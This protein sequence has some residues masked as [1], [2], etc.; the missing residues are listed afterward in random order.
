[1]RSWRERL[2]AAVELE[3]A[4]P[5]SPLAALWTFPAMIGSAF[6]VS[7]GAEAAEFLMSQGLALAV[8]ALVQ[9]MPEFA[10]EAVIAW[11]AGKDP[12]MVHLA[13][14]NFT[15]SLR[16]LT[17]LGWP[18]IYG[19]AA[20]FSRRK[21]RRLGRIVLADDHAV[22]VLGLLPPLAYFVVVWAKSNLSLID[23][24]VLA[25][26]YVAYLAVLLRM[27]PRDELPE[28][29]GELPRVSRWALSYTG[30]KR[31]AAVMALLGGGGA[32]IYFVAEPFLTS[33]MALAATFGMSQFVF[34]Q[35]VAPFLSEFPEKTSAFAWAKR[36]SRAPVALLNMVSSN[37]NQ[38]G[39]LSGLL[40]VIYCVS[41]GSTEPLPFDDFQRH[42]ILLTI[43]QAFLG[44][45]FLA[46]M[47]FEAY[48]AAGLFIL[49]LIQFL[50][51]STRD[52]MVFVYVSWIVVELILLGTGRKKLLAFGA[53]QRSWRARRS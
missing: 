27:P 50:I 3:S 24:A 43:V 28:E 14:A 30:W 34:I 44:W 31:W 38:W 48:E 21:G 15:G 18:M 39:I 6:L 16:L 7:W 45:L 11:K 52:V 10:V 8:L 41:H 53:F 17:G 35:W 22:E 25:A 20:F 49:W 9:T 37:I 26:T 40:A 2:V 12:S 32:V 5:G 33:M 4:S 42:E 51:P 13:I 1:M 23:S 19:V 47:S 36:I 46:S 29:D